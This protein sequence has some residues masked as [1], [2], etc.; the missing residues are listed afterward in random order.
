ML[1]LKTCIG[2]TCRDPWSTLHPSGDVHSLNDALDPSYDAYYAS[3]PSVHFDACLDDYQVPNEEPYF[4]GTRPLS[5]G[6]LSGADSSLNSTAVNWKQTIPADGFWGQQYEDLATLEV[7]ARDLTAAELE[8]QGD[9]V[10]E[11]SSA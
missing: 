11:G 3:L 7:R 6:P 4:P 2:D 8:Y 1:L 10:G 5:M 9:A